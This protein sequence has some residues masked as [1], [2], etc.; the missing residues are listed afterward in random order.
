[1]HLFKLLY[2]DDQVENFWYL[3]DKT[4]LSILKVPEMLFL[5]V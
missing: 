1:M 2:N 3:L 5:F 4:L